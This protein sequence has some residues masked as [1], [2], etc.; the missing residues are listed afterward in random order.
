MTMNRLYAV[1]VLLPTLVLFLGCGGRH[2]SGSTLPLSP[3]ALNLVFVVSPDLAFQT[4]GDLQ[5]DTANL[6]PQGLQRSLLLATYLKQQVL[7]D[8]NVDGIYALSP[9]TH[10][11][12]ANA[13]PDMAAIGFVQ[14]FSVLN[15]ITVRI[16]GVGGVLVPDN[17][18]KNQ[19][20]YIIRH[21]EA[22]PDPAHR[23]EDGNIV[24]A[25]QW[26]ALALAEALRGK[27]RPTLV[28]SCDPAQWVA[29]GYLNISYV[30][31][32]LTVLPYAIA[33]NLPYY[34]AAGFSLLDPNEPQLASDFFFTGGRFSNQTL[35]LAWESSRIKTMINALLA[36]YGGSGLPL[37]P[38]TWP[39]ADYDTIWTVRLD[40][41]GNVT[42]D[43]ELCEGIDSDKLPVTAPLFH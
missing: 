33:N 11:Q 30:R 21:A 31:P 16:G 34:L 8:R 38:P 27:V 10:L 19:R 32:A 25:G 22:H 14:Q 41:Q 17:I 36:T 7:G 35:L 39:S 15:Q 3:A 18:N 12:T 5:P 42:V 1:V 6:S 26:R 29:T 20:V 40:A 43:N 28:W 4:A 2:G 13:Y 37:L 24:A 23:F 9:M